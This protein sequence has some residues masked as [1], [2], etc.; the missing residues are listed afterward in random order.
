[1]KFKKI[2][3]FLV[4]FASIAV[5]FLLFHKNK[6][7]QFIPKN[8]DIV[9]LVDVKNLARQYVYNLAMHPSE[10]FAEGEKE[11]KSISLKNSG[12]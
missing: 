7:L 10:W 5:Y 11:K 4:L 2:L 12:L 1:M 3:F 6:N 8:A 9:V